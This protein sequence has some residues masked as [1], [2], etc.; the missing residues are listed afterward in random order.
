MPAFCKPSVNEYE[1]YITTTI[2]EENNTVFL[3]GIKIEVD[4]SFENKIRAIKNKVPEEYQEVL[5][6]G[7]KN[8]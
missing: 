1:I 2:D 7:V 6:V 8:E 4:K 5:K 3:E